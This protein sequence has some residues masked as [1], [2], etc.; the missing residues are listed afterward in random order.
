M[1]HFR[2]GK[3]QSPSV[4]QMLLCPALKWQFIFVLQSCEEL[5]YTQAKGKLWSR[6]KGHEIIKFQ[7][8]V[9][10]LKI[11]TSV[12]KTVT[13]ALTVIV[14]HDGVCPEIRSFSFLDKEL[15]WIPFA[16]WLL[17]SWGSL[18]AVGHHCQLQS[19]YFSDSK[20]CSVLVRYPRSNHCLFFLKLSL[21]GWASERT[22]QLPFHL[23]T[24]YV[25]VR[26]AWFGMVWVV[27]GW[28]RSTNEFSCLWLG[29]VSLL[30]DLVISILWKAICT[31]KSWENGIPFLKEGS[32]KA[33][34]E[35]CELWVILL[36]F[37]CLL[38][39]QSK[40]WADKGY[41]LCNCAL[42]C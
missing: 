8:T 42:P 19:L 30:L 15:I 20:F 13:N 22:R 6:S 1:S 14:S 24:N 36:V 5:Q 23:N 16:G 21:C 37:E 33:L 28:C 7:V 2:L 39:F 38:H 40:N 32:C 12:L 11:K 29:F 34:V 4:D 25:S 41:I 26:T 10:E 18:K 17:R 9:Y 27:W 31:I 35:T 3:Q